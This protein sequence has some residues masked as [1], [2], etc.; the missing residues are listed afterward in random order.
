MD[1]RPYFNWSKQER[2]EPGEVS[3]QL[4]FDEEAEE[5]TPCARPQWFHKALG[6]LEAAGLLK[7]EQMRR[8]FV[9]P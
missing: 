7:G 4:S 6:L 1:N 8:V 9:L 2:G 3:L 5:C